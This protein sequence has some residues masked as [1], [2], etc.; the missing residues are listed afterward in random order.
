M[1]LSK[2][3]QVR[4]DE[5]RITRSGETA[6]VEYKEPGIPTTNLMIGPKIHEM[7]DVDIVELFNETLRAQAQLAAQHP[8]VVVEVPLGSPQ[9]EYHALS[10]QW[11]PR[12][13]VL[14]CRIDSDEDGQA[15]VEIDDRELGIEEF[16]RLLATYA[17]WG[18][19]IEFVAE[20]EI[21]R[22]PALQVRE[23]DAS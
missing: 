21:H 5:V 22:R 3:Y 19:R 4:P 7:T 14:R 23:P 1:R 15:T 16:G 2:R 20:D 11:T 10:G 9:I 13:S 17:G 18:M 8:H 6:I 12:G